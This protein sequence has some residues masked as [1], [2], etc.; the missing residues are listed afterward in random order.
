M[1]TYRLATKNSLGNVIMFGPAMSRNVA[2]MKRQA[3]A[4]LTSY[5]VY[6]L[7]VNAQ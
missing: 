2:E 7:N 4:S 6:M 1:K 5:P 3:L